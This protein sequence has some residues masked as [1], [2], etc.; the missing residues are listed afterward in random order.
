MRVLP[1]VLAALLFTG[2]EGAI[3]SGPGASAPDDGPQSPGP[4][5]PGAPAPA[6]SACRPGEVLTRPAPVRR[7]TRFEYDNTVR[8]LLGDGSRPAAAFP[9]E[10]ESL[11]FSNN[12]SALTTSPALVEQLLSA[13]EALAAR[14]TSRL[15]QLGW[16]SCPQGTTDRGCAE[17]FVDAFAPRAFRRPLEAAERDALLALYDRG[18]SIGGLDGTTAL[19]PLVAGLRSVIEGVLMSPDFLYRL[20]LA[21]AGQAGAVRLPPHAIAARLSYLLWASMPD[22]ALR[23]AADTGALAAPDEVAAQARRLLADPRARAVVGDFHQQWLDYDRVTNAGKA[24]AVFPEWSAAVADS[25]RRETRAFVE[26]VVFDGEG[27]FDAL[28]TAP[29]TFVDSRLGGFYGLAN[30]P[31]DGAF[32]KVLVDP[33]QRGGLLTQGSLLALNA[34]SNQTSPV[35]RGKLVREAFLCTILP[36][37][38]DDV[39]IDVPEPLEGSTARERFKEHSSNASCAA[40]HKLMDPLGFGF[41]HFDGQGKWRAT[42]NGAPVDA[43]GEIVGSDVAGRFSGVPALAQKLAVSKQVRGCYVKQWLR[44]GLGRSETAED[45]CTLERLQGAFE[46]S[47]GDVLALLEALTQSDA[48]LYTRGAP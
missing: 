16:Y 42:E 34:H 12:G 39:V 32:A 37:P 38:P 21:P 28:M 36:A 27:T 23:A 30:A 48:F 8:D 33:A 14:A 5:V 41:E 2:C 3:V 18:A 45:A 46:A 43:S 7:M 24:A 20:E 19:P 29:Y 13:A 31:A 25:M 47:G 35:H 6:P 26:H 15:G 22:D 9:A 10:E 11:G 17:R 4:V 44:Y 40:C 1:I